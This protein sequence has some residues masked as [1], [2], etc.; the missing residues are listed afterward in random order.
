MIPKNKPI[1]SRQWLA[2]VGELG[3]CVLCGAHGVQVAHRNQG[4]GLSTKCDDLLSAALCPTC[5]HE[6]DNGRHLTQ[7]Q[8]RA[9]MNEAI[10]RTWLQLARAGKVKVVK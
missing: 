8:R 7:E 9:Q 6:I 2:N 5:H 1:R 4:R 3:V 10:I